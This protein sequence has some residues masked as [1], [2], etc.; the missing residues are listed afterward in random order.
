MST[1][2]EIKLARYSETA[3]EA[4]EMGRVITVHRLKPSEQTKIASYTAD[5]NGYD[6]MLNDKGEKIRIP[7][8]MPLIV[9]AA[10]CQIDDAVIPFAKNSGEL[11]AIYDRLD[12][13]GLR[14]A[15]KAYARLEGAGNVADDS[16]AI[17]PKD[18][19]K[20]L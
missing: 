18:E 16:N 19:T 8:R 15:G 17:S 9:S 20:N 4:D 12:Y 13:E 11:Y 1:E 6:E 14:A 10:V 5:L 7:H 3:K 2:S